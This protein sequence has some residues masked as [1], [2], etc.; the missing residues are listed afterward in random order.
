MFGG[1]GS[2]SLEELYWLG[3]IRI[4]NLAAMLV[5]IVFSSE[6]VCHAAAELRQGGRAKKIFADGCI[7]ILFFLCV[8]N[9]AENSYNLFI[10]FWC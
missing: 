7:F 1:S 5:G 2:G 3:V 4:P 6:K 8:V 9:L 10:Y